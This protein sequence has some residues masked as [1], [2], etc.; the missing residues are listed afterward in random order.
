MLSFRKRGSTSG[1][2]FSVILRFYTIDQINHRRI[3]T[4]HSTRISIR[5]QDGKDKQQTVCSLKFYKSIFL[6]YIALKHF[7]VVFASNDSFG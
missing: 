5:I 6:K 7:I 3:E 4:R 2:I 1:F